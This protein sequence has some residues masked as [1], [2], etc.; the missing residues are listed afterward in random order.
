MILHLEC[1]LIDELC[2]NCIRNPSRRSGLRWHSVSSDVEG[3]CESLEPPV[4]TRAIC[5]Y[6][7]EDPGAKALHSAE[8]LE[9]E[10]LGDRLFASGVA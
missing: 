9:E 7:V 3:V 10:A 6:D 1:M 5:G 8:V 2:T 4:D